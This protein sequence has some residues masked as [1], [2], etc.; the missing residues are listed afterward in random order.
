[1]ADPVEQL[2]VAAT[3]IAAKGGPPPWPEIE[4]LGGDRIAPLPY[5]VDSLSP[6]IRGAVERYQRFGQ[7]PMALIASSALSTAS[8]ATQGLA[9]VAR[10]PNLSGPCSLNFC[11][12]ARSGERKTSCDRRFRV[13]SSRW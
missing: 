4:A 9:D 5:P 6:T 12:I 11:I 3:E 7:Q 13:A 8:L 2:A 10:D 1:M